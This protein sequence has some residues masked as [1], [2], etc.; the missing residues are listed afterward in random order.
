MIGNI[1]NSIRG[2]FHA[3]REKHI[4][5]YLGEF[6]FNRFDLTEFFHKVVKNSVKASPI[7]T[8][9]IKIG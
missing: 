4:P 9:M 1:K 5:R 6:C 2:T 8:S 3:I 7:P